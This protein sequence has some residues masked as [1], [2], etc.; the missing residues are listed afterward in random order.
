MRS[1]KKKLNVRE[2]KDDAE[3]AKHDTDYET[4]AREK[5]FL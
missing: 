4:Y 2:V 5:I 1:I 3:Y